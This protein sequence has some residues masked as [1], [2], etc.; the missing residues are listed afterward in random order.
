MLAAE[1]LKSID[2]IGIWH[3]RLHYVTSADI[4]I[5]ILHTVGTRA[6]GCRDDDDESDAIDNHRTPDAV[7]VA[8]LC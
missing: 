7:A 3:T 6:A 8:G 2:E 4:Y 1:T 5:Y